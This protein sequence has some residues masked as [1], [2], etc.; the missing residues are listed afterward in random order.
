M[1]TLCIIFHDL[2]YLV[3]FTE[4]IYRYTERDFNAEVCLVGIG[5]IEALALANVSSV[6]IGTASGRMFLPALSKS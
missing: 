3:E 2:E 4:E 5:E 6:P 1:C